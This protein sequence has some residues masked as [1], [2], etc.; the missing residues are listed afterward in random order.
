MLDFSTEP[1]CRLFLSPIQVLPVF[2]PPSP[3]TLVMGRWDQKR[4]A[5]YLGPFPAPA[6]TARENERESL[7]ASGDNL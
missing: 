4:T 2:V 1:A 7:Y 6:D 5:D 3:A